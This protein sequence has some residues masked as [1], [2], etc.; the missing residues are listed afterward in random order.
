[1]SAVENAEVFWLDSKLRTPFRTAAG[2]FSERTSALVRLTGPDGVQGWG[3]YAPW[4]SA[5]RSATE[6]FERALDALERNESIDDCVTEAFGDFVH[7]SAAHAALETALADMEARQQNVP[8]A[9]LLGGTSDV[10]S[11]AVNG[12]LGTEGLEDGFPAVKIKV[13]AGTADDDITTVHAARDRFGADVELRL[14]ANGAWSAKDAI[15]ILARLEDSLPAYIEQPTP[16]PIIAALAHVHRE[17]LIPVF[18]DESVV[19]M[20][21]LEELVH[22]N[23]VRGICIKLPRVGG[24][25]SAVA[26][27]R[28]ALDAGLRV[29]IS[30][31]FEFGVGLAAAVHVAA[32]IDPGEVHGLAT[33]GMLESDVSSLLVPASGRV[34]VPTGPGLGITPEL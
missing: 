8:L 15:K 4:P 14:D 27:G 5:S 3:E 32:T 26:I 34:S 31:N 10:D 2:T 7:R 19:D 22:E 24:P 23:A 18:A 30:S 28:R 16:G 13:G 21:S 25:R 17:S 11:I 9:Q 1:M 12:I 6:P 29:V 20:S 33:G